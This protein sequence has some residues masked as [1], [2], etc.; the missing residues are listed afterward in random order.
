MQLRSH[1]I[2]SSQPH[3]FSDASQQGYGV[4]TLRI[5][6]DTGKFHY[7]Y[8]YL[9]TFI[10]DK[11]FSIIHTVINMCPS[12]FVICS[13]V[14]GKSRLA[15]LKPVTI[16]RMKLSAAI[17]ATRLDRI[18]RQELSLLV[19]QSSFWTDNTCV[20]RYIENETRRY[21]AFAANRIG[22]QQYEMHLHRANGDTFI[23]NPTQMMKHPKE[24]QPIPFSVG[25]MHGPNF[26]VQPCETWPQRPVDMRYNSN[27]D[28]EIK[29][30]AKV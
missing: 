12:S 13:F 24:S 9:R 5:V 17:V 10:E 29:K 26:V 25:Y 28:P 8:Y 21:Q 20:L 14:M 2:K 7:Y 4:V 16:P 30:S 19:D 6:D 22:S 18:T 3:H 15:P 11:H 27:D 23:S 1:K